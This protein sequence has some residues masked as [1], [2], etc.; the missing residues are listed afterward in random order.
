MYNMILLHY[1][2]KRDQSPLSPL[3][4]DGEQPQHEEEEVMM[5]DEDMNSDTKLWKKR[6]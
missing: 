1:V 4:G 6:G 2:K 3:E 5:I